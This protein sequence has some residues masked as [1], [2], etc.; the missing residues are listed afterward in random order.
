MPGPQVFESHLK[1]TFGNYEMQ[2]HEYEIV[3]L[4]QPLSKYFI[5]DKI[6]P[7][8]ALLEETHTNMREVVVPM[9]SKKTLMKGIPYGSYQRR[10]W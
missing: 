1:L 10:T 9:L 7:E 4:H 8:A 6:L 5:S 2:S 3:L